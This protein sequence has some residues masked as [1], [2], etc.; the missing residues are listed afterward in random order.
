VITA[1]AKKGATNKDDKKERT[2]KK[3]K[4]NGKVDVEETKETKVAKK[5]G[6]GKAKR[7]ATIE[8]KRG[9]NASG[10]A[11]REQIKKAVAKET[12][13]V[14]RQKMMMKKS[15]GTVSGSLKISFIPSDIGKGVKKGVLD[16]IKG[17]LSKQ[18]SKG[19]AQIGSNNGR[20]GTGSTKP[21]K[22]PPVNFGRRVVVSGGR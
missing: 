13:A 15:D 9:L 12:I 20:P 3:S 1:K 19:S 10:K 21:K 18:N 5:V 4:E 16:Q 17:A 11:S 6:E 8:Q 14:A 7:G 2:K 22:Q